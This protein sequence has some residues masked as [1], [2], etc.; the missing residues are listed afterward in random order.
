MTREPIPESTAEDARR[1]D[2]RRQT[3]RVLASGSAWGF[4]FSTFWLLPKYLD[5]ELGAG[6][7]AIGLVAGV[8]GVATLAFA[9]IAG[10]WVDRLPHRRTL[11]A[12]SL[13]MAASAIGFL[14]AD[15]VGPT[16][17]ALRVLQSLSH[18]LMMTAVSVA[19]AELAP[20]E[21]LSQAL[22]FAGATMLVMNAI[23]PA[24]AEPLAAAAGW[25]AVFVL[26]AA[27]ALF[28]ATLAASIP[29]LPHHVR[30]VAHGPDGLLHVLRRPVALHFAAVTFFA[31]V[32]FGVVFTFEPP[33]ALALGREEVRGFFIAFALAAVVVR[34]LFG[35]APDRLGR[36]RIATAMLAAYA[37]GAFVMPSVPVWFLEPLGAVFGVAH[38]LFFP[39]VNAIALSAVRNGERGRMMA[40]FTGAFNLGLASTAILGLVAESAGYAAVFR[41][42][43]IAAGIGA[44]VLGGSGELR[45]ADDPAAR[46]IA[47]LG[48]A[49]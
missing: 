18:V 26:S 6:P 35:S 40:I 34:L 49:A 2:F 13:L 4:A 33:Y 3:A 10:R 38:G 14:F 11:V 7:T 36:H 47:L 46:R 39:S 8:F 24:I 23:A 30:P 31:G 43:A 29:S 44:V 22:G 27:A 45:R 16:M 17:L 48:R 41:T 25:P 1:R 21:R 9:P 42:A 19:I 28:A 12:G 15:S 37:A 20:A 32:A 5:R